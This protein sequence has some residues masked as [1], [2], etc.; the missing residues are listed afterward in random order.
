MKIR[1]VSAV[2]LCLRCFLCSAQD[3]VQMDSFRLDEITFDGGHYALAYVGYDS[4]FIEGSEPQ[5]FEIMREMS[6]GKKVKYNKE[7]HEDL[8]GNFDIIAITH[9]GF[10]IMPPS[11]RGMQFRF[12]P[13]QKVVKI[14][15]QNK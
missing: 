14:L 6:T 7:C 4:V 8:L 15:R 11:E 10:L 5:L 9:G 13:T 3:E 2:L 12:V 1:F